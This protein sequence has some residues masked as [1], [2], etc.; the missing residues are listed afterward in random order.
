MSRAE[1][2][3]ASKAAKVAERVGNLSGK[4]LG[5][6]ANKLGA[7]MDAFGFA[8]RGE[9][10][11]FQVNAAQATK[12]EV[13]VLPSIDTRPMQ[14]PAREL[15]MEEVVSAFK[16]AHTQSFEKERAKTRVATSPPK[17]KPA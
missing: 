13:Q 2:N 5:R 3:G 1:F 12:A 7:A 11:N 4:L 9:I 14:R 15:A 17:F 6:V 10:S 8:S 16:R